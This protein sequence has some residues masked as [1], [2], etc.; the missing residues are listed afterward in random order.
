MN[1]PHI[2]TEPAILYFGTPVVLISTENEDGTANLAPMSSAFWLGWRC[3]LGLNATS[4]TSENMIRTG[5]CVL[6][7]PSANEVE[8]VDRIAMTTGSNPVPENKKPRGY[9]Y[10]PHKFERAHLTAIP[11]N[12][13]RPPR[14]LECPV[15]MEAMVMA[16]HG[17]NEDNPKLKGFVLVF[18]VKVVKVHAHPSILKGDV[19]NQ[20]DPDKWKPLIM[21]FQKFYGLAPGQLH[22]SKL[23]EIPEAAYRGPNIGG[24]STTSNT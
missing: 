14:V 6:N 22:S 19:P 11:S 8:A 24:K 13:V 18:E 20:V 3:M 16:R 15:Q 21:S 1:D 23:G 5:E 9:V 7:L 4:K 17:I 12:S 2:L 10:E